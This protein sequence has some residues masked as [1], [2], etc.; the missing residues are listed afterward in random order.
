MVSVGTATYKKSIGENTIDFIF[1][2]PLLLKSLV[3]CKIIE[4]LDHNLDHQPILS[5]WPLQ[6]IDK[7][8]DFKRLLA[9]IDSVL[10]IKTLQEKLASLLPL[11][12]KTAKELD[13]KVVFLV[14][15]I[16]IAMDAFISIAKL[17]AR[18]IL[19]FDEDCKDAQMRTRRLKKIWK[20]EDTEDGWEA[21]RL[22]RA[23]KG[24]MIAKI[25]KKAYRESR[26]EACNFPEELWKAI[27]QAKNRAPKQSCLPNI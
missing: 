11:S 27:R 25:K 19:R 16:D 10:L 22:A 9:K 21:F 4:D 18:S 14:K 8:A 20:K 13:K 15:A 7:P 1:A 24:R 23:E 3:C 5:K 17:C 26:A 6:M 2:T 12:L